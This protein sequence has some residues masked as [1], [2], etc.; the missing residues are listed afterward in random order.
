MTLPKKTPRQTAE[1]HWDYIESI[2]REEMRMKRKMFIDAFV[3][4]FKHGRTK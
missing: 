2:L 3:H 4:G 1:E